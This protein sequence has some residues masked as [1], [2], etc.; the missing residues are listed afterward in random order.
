MNYKTLLGCLCI[1]SGLSVLYYRLANAIYFN[2]IDIVILSITFGAGIF[3][4][5]KGREKSKND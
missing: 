3:F 5:S 2:F 1:G 4:I